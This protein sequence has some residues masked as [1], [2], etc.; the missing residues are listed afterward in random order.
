[1]LKYFEKIAVNS[2]LA[3]KYKTNNNLIAKYRQKYKK[4]RDIIC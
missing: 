3:L 2:E 1:M 4:R